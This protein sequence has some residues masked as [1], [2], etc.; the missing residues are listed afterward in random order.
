MA[1]IRLSQIESSTLKN[2][3]YAGPSV[4][5]AFVYNVI[6][7]IFKDKIGGNW[8]LYTFEVFIFNFLYL[9]K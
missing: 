9:E 8:G 4:T 7:F 3:S 5:C 2:S 1:K 6:H